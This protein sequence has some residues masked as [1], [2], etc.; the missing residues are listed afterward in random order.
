MT[1]PAAS[2]PGQGRD[3]NVQPS[4]DA[5]PTQFDARQQIS[6]FFDLV[7]GPDDAGWLHCPTC[8]WWDPQGQLLKEW[9]ENQCTW[10]DREA[11]IDWILERDAAGFDVYIV[12]NILSTDARLEGTAVSRR[13]A[14][15][16]VDEG[17]FDPE[18]LARLGGFAVASGSPGNAHVYVRLSRSV[19]ASEHAALCRGLKSYFGAKDPKISDNDVLRVPGTTNRKSPSS[20]RPVRLVPHQVRE[21]DPV[22]LAQLLGVGL[23]SRDVPPLEED[24][25]GTYINTQGAMYVP[26]SPTQDDGTAKASLA[27]EYLRILRTG[28]LSRPARGGN[29]KSK[30]EA[31]ISVALHAINK[32]VSRARFTEYV[33]DSR[34]NSSTWREPRRMPDFIDRAWEKADALYRRR[35]PISCKADAQ[36]FVERVQRQAQVPWRGKGGPVDQEVFK[37]LLEHALALGSV[38]FN[39]SLRDIASHS[40][41]SLHAVSSSI[42][43]IIAT[44]RLSRIKGGN[45]VTRHAAR[46]RL[47]LLPESFDGAPISLSMPS[48]AHD[49]WS[50]LPPTAKQIYEALLAEPGTVAQLAQRT[51]RTPQ[52]VRRQLTGLAGDDLVERK[53]DGVWVALQADL[54]KLADQYSFSGTLG[55]RNEQFRR[56]RQ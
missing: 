38:E 44:G 52:T 43:R 36:R 25:S 16:D 20:P 24:D 22:E 3:R 7:F 30:S 50:G 12:P 40:G 37:V 2:D 9:E 6:E 5:V 34:N 45:G 46:Y 42:H 19:S 11:A 15:A 41:R 51:G 54:D 27:P 4:Q 32:G 47:H 55:R 10:P 8:L 29:Y 14:H 13:N 33:R 21:V 39:V 18:K 17:K 48:V 23:N 28:D 35:P 31:L 1:Q 26:E 56:D 53:D 49:Y